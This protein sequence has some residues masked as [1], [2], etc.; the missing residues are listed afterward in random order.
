MG[1]TSFFVL[2][3]LFFLLSLV[4]VV[5]LTS[6]TE[7]LRLNNKNLPMFLY[8]VWD[9]KDY[10]R[11]GRISEFNIGLKDDAIHCHTHRMYLCGTNSFTFPWVIPKDFPQDALEQDDLRKLLEFI[12]VRNPKLK[13]TNAQKFV[14][15]LL[16]VLYHP[17]ARHYHRWLR[18]T[19]FYE[20]REAFYKH[21]TP[22]FW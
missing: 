6:K 13:F 18:Q 16:C 15:K 4:I 12:Q 14:Y 1:G 19:K 20:L 8:K 22:Q 10:S 11:R 17:I 7:R 2:V 9:N 21:F 5:T 3:M